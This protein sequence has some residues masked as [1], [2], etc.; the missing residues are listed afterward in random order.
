[1]IFLK[2]KITKTC[3]LLVFFLGSM[4]CW[5][6]IALCDSILAFY[7]DRNISY[8]FEFTY[9]SSITGT[10]VTKGAVVGYLDNGIQYRLTLDSL[11]NPNITEYMGIECVKN[12]NNRIIGCNFSTDSSYTNF[13][14]DREGFH[15]MV[16]LYQPDHIFAM[17]S[18]TKMFTDKKKFGVD[19]RRTSDYIYI[20]IEEIIDTNSSD[21]SSPKTINS[22]YKYKVSKADYSVHSLKYYSDFKVDG[23]LFRDS[24]KMVFK[25]RAFS[26][27]WKDRNDIFRHV[28]AFKPYKKVSGNGTAPQQTISYFPNFTLMDTLKEYFRST[29]IKSRYTLVEFW[30]KGCLPCMKSIKRLNSIRDSFDVKFLEVIGIND[31]DILDPDTKRFISKFKPNYTILFNGKYLRDDLNVTAHPTTFIFDNKTRKVVFHKKG[32]DENYVEEIITELN[33]RR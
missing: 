26:K 3:L 7:E 32:T 22:I 27:A 16:G 10:D 30:Y 8:E 31:A 13:E 20:T 15:Q 5:S 9:Y 11:K 4:C 25:N 2:K 19:V 23:V 17:D 21:N 29:D 24:S 28:F 12:K 14:R 1:M 33:K 6:Q 18:F